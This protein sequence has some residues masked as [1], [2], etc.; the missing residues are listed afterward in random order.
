MTEFIPATIITLICIAPLIIIGIVQCLSKEPVGFWAGK[1]PPKKEDVTDVKAYNRKHG[2][3]WI[4]YGAGFFL[5]FLSG[6]PFGGVAA[7]AA[8]GVE[9]II[10]LFLMIWYHN[11]L[12]HRYV[13]K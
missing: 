5:C 6:L 2:M 12:E 8:S 11:R 13:K 7:A 9:C 1:E 3:M 4:A 10:G